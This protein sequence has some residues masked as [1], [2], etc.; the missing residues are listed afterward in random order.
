MH[1]Y[2]YIYIVIYMQCSGMEDLYAQLTCKD[3]Y[4]FCLV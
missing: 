2:I 3:L 1:I 4:I